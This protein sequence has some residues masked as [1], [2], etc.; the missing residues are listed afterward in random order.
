MSAQIPSVESYYKKLFPQV[1]IIYL[2]EARVYAFMYLITNNPS[3]SFRVHSLSK[4]HTK[5]VNC[6]TSSVPVIT[7]EWLRLKY[8][9]A[10]ICSI[11][12]NKLQ[13]SLIRV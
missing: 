8:I 9:H 4:L 12:I 3:Y 2:E 5:L 7:L 6:I 11:L 10:K 13:R 1:N